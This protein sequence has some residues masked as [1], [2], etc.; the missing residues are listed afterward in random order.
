MAVPPRW[1]FKR[2][3]QLQWLTAALAGYILLTAFLVRTRQATVAPAHSASAALCRPEMEVNVLPPMSDDNATMFKD[4]FSYI[5]QPN[6]KTCGRVLRFGGMAL[7][8]RGMPPIED[9]HKYVCVDDEF[10]ILRTDSCLVYSFGVSD[11]WSFDWDM[12][13]FGCMVYSFDPSINTTTGYQNGSIIFL[14]YG[15]G[16]RD[17]SAEHEWEIRTLD[18]FVERLKHAGRTIQY[19]KMDVEN[20]EW[21]VL[22]QQVKRGRD[23]TLFKNVEQLGIELHFFR[24][25]ATLENAAFYREVYASFLGLQQMGFYL[26]SYE[27]N[28]SE[29]PHT[30]IPGMDGKWPR[31]MEVVWLKTKCVN[32]PSG[33][34]GT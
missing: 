1:Y 32:R 26:F 18:T 28:L 15:V 14:Q 11:D 16:D 6:S 21:Q 9:G 5:T 2:K 8:M 33:L 13:S 20:A 12:E 3:T 27:P 29:E 4:L 34:E 23:S 10:S 25:P 17:Y 7:M 30:R 24:N 22:R 31:A 19:L